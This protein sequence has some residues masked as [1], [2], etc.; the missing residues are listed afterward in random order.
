MRVLWGSSEGS[1]EKLAVHEAVYSGQINL[2]RLL[3]ANSNEY[4]HK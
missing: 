2:L 1:K 3:Q 4:Y